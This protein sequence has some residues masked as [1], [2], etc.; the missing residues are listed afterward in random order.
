MY[1]G[2]FFNEKAQKYY[3]SSLPFKEVFEMVIVTPPNNSF[4][5]SI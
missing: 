4:A 1:N 3:L 2:N 5:H